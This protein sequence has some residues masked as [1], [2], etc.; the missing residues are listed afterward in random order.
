MQTN[1][2]LKTITSPGLLQQKL[3]DLLGTIVDRYGEQASLISV[4]QHMIW[5]PEIQRQWANWLLSA[6]QWAKTNLQITNSTR[7]RVRAHGFERPFCSLVRAALN[8]SVAEKQSLAIIASLY[9]RD[10]GYPEESATIGFEV[11]YEALPAFQWL[12]ANWRR[13]IERLWETLN[14]EWQDNGY[15]ARSWPPK[16]SGWIEPRGRALMP[17]IDFYL[18]HSVTEADRIFSVH[19]PIAPRLPKQQFETAILVQFALLDA[20]ASLCSKRPQPDLLLKHFLKLESR[21][22]PTSFRSRTAF[23][24]FKSAEADTNF[25]EH[26]K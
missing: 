5:L 14:P 26:D 10:R 1:G 3:E 24:K 23:A 25:V 13:L 6:V 7:F 18:Q 12:L 19:I 2:Y 4:E 11:G 16:K 15:S 17:K 22:A 20:V 9:A 21:L 8:S